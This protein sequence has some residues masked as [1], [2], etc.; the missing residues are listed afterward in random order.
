MHF[1]VNS[2]S[3][4]PAQMTKVASYAHT[5][6]Q[7]RCNVHIDATILDI[8]GKKEDCRIDELQKITEGRQLGR[9]G[10]ISYLMDVPCIERP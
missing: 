7:T 8:F 3:R 2:T 4:G 1:E 10:G 5:K 9:Q 6:S